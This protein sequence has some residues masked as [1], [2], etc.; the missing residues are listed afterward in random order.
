MEERETDT[1]YVRGE[2]LFAIERGG[3]GE[4][5]LEEGAGSG[6]DFSGREGDGLGGE[7]EVGG[8]DV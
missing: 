3:E 7:R 8:G 1:V 6:G 2:Y 4:L 5:A